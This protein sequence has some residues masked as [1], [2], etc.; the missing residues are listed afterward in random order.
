MDEECRRDGGVLVSEPGLVGTN[1]PAGHDDGWMRSGAGMEV[2]LRQSRAWWPPVWRRAAMTARC[3]TDLCSVGR[4]SDGGPR[5]HGRCTTFGEMPVL[6]PAPLQSDMIG[7]WVGARSVLGPVPVMDDCSA[8]GS[9]LFEKLVCSVAESA[10]A[11]LLGRRSALAICS[12]LGSAPHFWIIFPAVGSR[13][14]RI[15]GRRSG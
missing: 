14:D 2:R 4:R 7:C 12:V 11:Q 6:G 9:A 15:L 1:L 8:A 3:A 10:P 5:G 13:P